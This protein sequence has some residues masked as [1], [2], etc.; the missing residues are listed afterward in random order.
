[1]IPHEGEEI[2][3]SKLSRILVCLGDT[4]HE[5]MSNAFTIVNGTRSVFEILKF[6]DDKYQET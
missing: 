3:S 2:N 6:V 5:D 4:R 1:M